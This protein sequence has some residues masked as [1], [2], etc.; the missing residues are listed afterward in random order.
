MDPR[1]AYEIP[2]RVFY[3]TVGSKDTAGEQ[4]SQLP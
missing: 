1:T 2:K 4:K 3:R